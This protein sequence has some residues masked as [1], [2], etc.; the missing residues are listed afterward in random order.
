MVER[1]ETYPTRAMSNEVPWTIRQN[2]L[3]SDGGSSE[4][5]SKRIFN[6]GVAKRQ[7]DTHVGS[8]IDRVS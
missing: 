8:L 3:R 5:A 1:C 6:G 4:A 7:A 2:R